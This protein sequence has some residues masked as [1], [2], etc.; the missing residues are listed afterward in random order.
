MTTTA[1]NCQNAILTMIVDLEAGAPT[2]P[3]LF[4]DTNCIQ[5]GH[6]WKPSVN[7]AGM[8][9]QSIK[10]KWCA[11]DSWLDPQG[12]PLPVIQ[13]MIIPSNM[14]VGFRAK[15]S[16]DLATRIEER[17]RVWVDSG[18][19]S[20]LNNTPLVWNNDVDGIGGCLLYDTNNITRLNLVNNDITVINDLPTLKA[21]TAKFRQSVLSCGSPFLPSVSVYTATGE[22]CD[23]LKKLIP[24][25]SNQQYYRRT[26]YMTNTLNANGTHA[27]T[28][29]Q[30]ALSILLKYSR[31]QSKIFT[32]N[33]NPVQICTST[34]PHHYRDLD[35]FFMNDPLQTSLDG[36][37]AGTTLVYGNENSG[38]GP[39]GSHTFIGDLQLSS[40][41]YISGDS[42]YSGYLFDHMCGVIRNHAN[43]DT[44]FGSEIFPDI[45]WVNQRVTDSNTALNEC[46]GFN[47]TMVDPERQLA[48]SPCDCVPDSM[49]HYLAWT[50]WNTM[51]YRVVNIQM[52]HDADGDAYYTYG[53]RVIESCNCPKQWR[54][55]GTVDEF[56]VS[57]KNHN[58]GW[59]YEKAMLCSGMWDVTIDNI[60]IKNYYHGSPLCDD[61]MKSY[62][63]RN[64]DD[65]LAT[66]CTCIN[67]ARELQVLFED[68]VGLSLHC[69][70]NSCNDARTNVYKTAEQTKLKCNQQ[71][72]EQKIDLLGSSISLNGSSNVLCNSELSNSSTILNIKPNP[73]TTALQKVEVKTTVSSMYQVTLLAITSFI[74]LGISVLALIV[75][76]YMRRRHKQNLEKLHFKTT[77]KKQTT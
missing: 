77:I 19:Y 60:P 73:S 68:S 64:I 23:Q 50:M 46:A 48:T 56:A 61:H 16:P 10:S 12:C 26:N 20:D 22:R 53:D 24:V 34:D 45:S 5:N 75:Y 13:S 31:N 35:N 55:E 6:E 44:L 11:N 37:T 33:L 14:K 39:W 17:G 1:S 47:E 38:A 43:Y 18:V 58:F 42:T 4:R 7:D 49:Y 3:Y 29:A 67:Q 66:A 9:Y 36:Y 28:P 71:V 69:L 51:N 2:M 76:W 54:I 59:D 15:W 41:W 72:C 27:L 30:A 74:I 25:S 8:G 52:H 65:R 62:C 21:F 32:Q 57:F 63:Q 70:I 40:D